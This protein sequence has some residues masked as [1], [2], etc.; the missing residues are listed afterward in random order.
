MGLFDDE[1]A[2]LFDEAT[3]RDKLACYLPGS[4]ELRVGRHQIG[5]GPVI[6]IEIAAHPD[7]AAVFTADGAFEHKGKQQLAFRRGE[8]FVRHGTKSELPNQADVHELGQIAVARERLWLDVLLR[9]QDAVAEAGR[10]AEAEGGRDPQKPV[11]GFDMF[12]RWPTARSQLGGCL[13]A[14]ERAGG[15][16]LPACEELAYGST[17]SYYGQAMSAVF[18]AMNEVAGALAQSR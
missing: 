12:S 15:P 7:G 5:D 11:V 3:V 14:L 18:S 8:F 9:V 6:L 4:L 1:K 16:R 2:K 13:A 10:V 17:I